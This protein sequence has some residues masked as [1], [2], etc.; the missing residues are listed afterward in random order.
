[1]LT[2]FSERSGPVLLSLAEAGEPYDGPAA[3]HYLAKSREFMVRVRELDRPG[4]RVNWVTL[5][6]NEDDQIQWRDISDTF[7]LLFVFSG[8]IQLSL[9]RFIK[10]DIH[11]RGVNLFCAEGYFFSTRFWKNRDYQ[12]IMIQY[13]ERF[14]ED[15]LNEA[16]EN[17]IKDIPRPGFYYDRSLVCT[18]RTFELL[19][20]LL[21]SRSAGSDEMIWEEEIARALLLDFLENRAERYQPAHLRIRDL[22]SFYSARE[23]LVVMATRNASFPEL[24]TLAEIKDI[25]EFRKRLGQLYGLNI[26]DFITETRLAKA[27]DLLQDPALSIKEV[28]AMTGFVNAFYFS[29]VFTRYYG[30]SPKYFRH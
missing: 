19:S 2:L 4:F 28:A 6:L 25:Y 12:L 26:R 29:R 14:A 11:D 3:A 1:M 13:P 23:R 27:A 7:I 10:R 18:Q 24:L 22:D 8:S 5:R 20:M 21:M 9:S 17:V 30:Q 16:H 15:H